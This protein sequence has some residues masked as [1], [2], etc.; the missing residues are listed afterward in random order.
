MRRGRLHRA[1]LRRRRA[2]LRLRRRLAAR[3]ARGPESRRRG[4]SA[5]GGRRAPAGPARASE[6]LI[7]VPAAHPVGAERGRHRQHAVR[8]IEH[9]ERGGVRQVGTHVRDHLRGPP[10]ARR[11]HAIREQHDEHL[12]VGINPDRRP[13]VAGVA[14]GALGEVA[15]GPAVAVGGVP[16]ERPRSRG[17]AREQRDRRVAGD[18]HAVVLTAVEHHLGEH[19][20]VGGGAEQARVSRD[21]AE[22][23]RVLVVHLAAE[24]V[25]ARRRVFRGRDAREQRVGGAIERVGHA[26]RHEDA[27]VQELVESL[28]GDGLDDHAQHVVAQIRVD[29]A[30]A[31]SAFERRVDDRQTRLLGVMRQAPEIAARGKAG[32]MREQLPNGDGVLEAAAERRK[33]ARDGR[34]EHQPAFVEEQHGRGRRADHLAQRREVVDG[35]IHGDERRFARPVEPSE[36][37]FQDR[38]TLAADDDRGAR[39]PARLDPPAHDAVDRLE[40]RSRHPHRPRRLHRK[41]VGGC[42]D[43]EGSDEGDEQQKL[44]GATKVGRPAHT[45]ASAH[46]EILSKR[47]DVPLPLKARSAHQQRFYF[48]TSNDLRRSRRA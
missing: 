13:G 22:R 46:D 35:A 7:P 39:I 47:G 44:L 26:K 10:G 19:A 6:S 15:P 14:V 4:G 27:L 16:A 34:V 9:R 37:L 31:G 48:M 1:T 18:P 40:P 28:A 25:A 29:E 8:R 11:V 20:E 21:A 32:A 24:R 30:A 2:C 36:P 43:D 5:S 42:G 12:A 17:A 38:C 41:T 23:V 3:A 33:V 45:R